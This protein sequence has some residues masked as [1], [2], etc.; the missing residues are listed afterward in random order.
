[1]GNKV[2]SLVLVGIGG[3]GNTYVSALRNYQG[4]KLFEIKGVVD[5]NPVTCR[6]LNWL[7]EQQIP[8]YKSIEEFYENSEADL[9][10]ISSPIQF[11]CPQ[12]CY[13]LEHGSNVLCEKPV[14]PTIQEAKKMAE[15]RDKTGKFV[16]IGYQWS[17]SKA[18]Q[19]LKKDI[20][21]GM[22]GKPKRLKTLVLWPRAK[23]YYGRNNWAGCK[24]AK[25]GNWILDSVVSNA[26]AHFLHNMF[27][28]LGDKTDTSAKPKSV[29]AELYRANDI[30]NYDTAAIRVITEDGAELLHF[31]SHAVKETQD[32]IFFYEFEEANVIFGDSNFGRNIVAFH[33]NGTWKQYG[34]PFKDTLNKLWMAIDSV[35][36]G[37]PVVCGIEAASSLTITVNAAQE[38]S[39]IVDF[40]KDMV[41]LD[42][43]R[44]LVWV[45]GIGDILKMC[46][47]SG[48]LPYEAMQRQ[49]QRGSH[50]QEIP[51]WIKPGKE[52]DTVGYN[53]FKGE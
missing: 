42:Q 29:T 50:R 32:P 41:E 16:A 24:K 30:E 23:S 10:I 18:I 27:Y 44:D 40:P 36:T 35:I 2:V 7:Q 21:S 49:A 31:A 34:D 22:F 52:I 53:Y 39:E 11:H 5:P 14:S 19:E 8:F 4:E 1:M 26:T 37:K 25:D 13:A 28:V 43:G 38:S 51:S 15:V 47:G 46:Y 12:V 20:Q 48:K 45:H 17:H 33:K 9:A 3:Y 6:D